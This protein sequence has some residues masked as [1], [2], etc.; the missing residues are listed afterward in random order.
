MTV[1]RVVLSGAAVA[2][3]AVWLFA[4]TL[5]QHRGTRRLLSPL[6]AYDICGLIP[7]WTFF[8]PNPGDTD[9]HL[10]FRDREASGRTTDWREVPLT[11]RRRM[12][13]LWNPRR[14]INKALVDLIY[15]LTRPDPEQAPATPQPLSKRRVLSFPYILVL[16]YVSRLPGDFGATER[17]FALAR[18]PG[19]RGRSR[20]DVVLV[21]AF[22]ELN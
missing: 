5:N 11:G 3:F 21:S 10:L 17:Q 20:P 22:H 19:L 1:V 4:T 15:D 2:V 18:S 8:A 14:R 13:D 16:N 12:T 9:V 6:L 7:I